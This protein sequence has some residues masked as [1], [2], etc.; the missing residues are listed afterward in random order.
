MNH[1]ILRTAFVSI[2]V[3]LLFWSSCAWIP[4][5]EHQT[6]FLEPPRMA[7]TLAE[8]KDRLAHWPDEQWWE[9]FGSPELNH[10]M[11]VALRDNPNLHIAT[12]RLREAQSIVRVEGARLLP[13]LD[14]DASLTNERIS[15]HGVFDAL[16]HGT[17][18]GANVLLGIIN[19]L[20]F[21]Y[22]FDFWGKN[23]ALLH[24]ALGQAAAEEAERAEVRLRLTAA[25]A[26]AYFRALAFQQQLD[27]AGEMVRIRQDLLRLVEIRF[28]F[29]LD[30]EL[31]VQQAEVDL[32]A[33]NKRAA[34]VRDQFD[35]H[36]YLLGRLS[37]AGPDAVRRLIIPTTAIRVGIPLPEHLP[38]GLL[39]HRPDL[40]ASL[41]RAQ[42]AAQREKVARTQFLPSIDLTGFVG[43]NA[44]V[45]T[46][47]ANQLANLLFSGQSFAYG[48][49]P[50][51]R[52]P[53]FEGGRLRGE[54]AARRAEYE[55]A[56]DLY[57]QTLLDAM[58]E[59]A[60]SLS[61]W[62]AARDIVAA[63]QR[64][65]AS[66]GRDWRLTKVRLVGGLDDNR[67]LLKHHHPVI[68]QEYALRILESDQLVAMV[69]LIEALGGGYQNHD[70]KVDRKTYDQ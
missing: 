70:V 8:V 55:G 53:W 62:Q 32:E 37:G 7:E 5:R 66:A 15:Q 19:P 36:R 27:L 50:G 23:R 43:F 49:A 28:R 3:C 54:L 46:K 16:S 60:A 68:E 29:G 9:Q 25:V 26:R 11:T 1:H 52:L 44:V 21:R 64:L 57:N 59:V 4:P 17:I 67:D 69:D 34:G 14:A 42:A 31:A 39:A 13:F 20:S 12:A 30:D 33:A 24:A 48:I 56:V 2:S 41:Y 45:F 10:I 18:S 38:I 40:A 61:A 6:E 47:G 22:E 51:L 63:H 65:L 35:V 58:R